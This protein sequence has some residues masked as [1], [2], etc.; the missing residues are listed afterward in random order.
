MSVV[1]L[2][3]CQRWKRAVLS[4]GQIAF[5]KEMERVQWRWGASDG[6]ASE[7]G[8]LVDKSLNI[9]WNGAG[10]R[11]IDIITA[12]TMS[13]VKWPSAMESDVCVSIMTS[14]RSPAEITAVV[15]ESGFAS[16]I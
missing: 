12:S 3:I 13:K 10:Y 8:G 15:C 2:K 7:V 9:C 16:D 1:G 14:E 4:L 6:M 11:E 5:D